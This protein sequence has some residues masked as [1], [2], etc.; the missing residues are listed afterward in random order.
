MVLIIDG[1]SELGTCEKCKCIF[2]KIDLKDAAVDVKKYFI[3]F[4]FHILLNTCAS[5]SDLPS[6]IYYHDEQFV[7]SSVY[8]DFI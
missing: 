5:Y 1:I 3:E 6:Y 2:S 8:L 4:K 7:R